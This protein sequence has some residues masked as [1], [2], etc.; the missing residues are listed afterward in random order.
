MD[1]FKKTSFSN[2]IIWILG[3]FFIW[4]MIIASFATVEFG[5][6]LL[7][8]IKMSNEMFFI[9]D[10]YTCLL[11]SI[12][13]YLLFCLIPKNRFLLELLKPTKEKKSFKLLG[14]GI[15]LGFATNFFCI[16]CA[17]IHK[18]IFLYFDFTFSQIPFL[19][20]AFI[21]VMFQS[22]SEELWCR[23]MLYERI[24]V[25]YPVWVSVFVNGSLFG[26]L[27]AMNPGI[28]PFALASLILCGFSYSLLRWYSGSIWT[29][30]GI[31]T[32]WNFTQN[33]LFGL[34]N[35]GLVSEASVFHLDGATGISNLIYDHS[36]GVEGAVPALLTDVALI[37][38][39]LILAK[40]NNRLG[41]LLLSQEKI[42]NSNISENPTTT[43]QEGI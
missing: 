27:H 11:A 17:L 26:L 42:E 35:S 10:M 39:I 28:T 40:K 9:V 24:N 8:N 29:C 31:H 20:F 13:V 23:G 14:I 15:L 30:I 36:F 2:R 22:A 3:A 43:L 5:N 38:V 34:P 19:I 7:F 4:Y 32:M 1:F 16:A 18:D 33:I 41:E 37:V 6:L 25:H 21:S 12:A